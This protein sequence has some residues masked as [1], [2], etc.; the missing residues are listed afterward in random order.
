MARVSTDA[1]NFKHLTLAFI[2]ATVRFQTTRRVGVHDECQQI[3]QHDA[4]GHIAQDYDHLVR[5]DHRRCGR[6]R[7]LSSG[8]QSVAF[9]V[10]AKKV[11]R[12]P[13]EVGIPDAFNTPH[14]PLML[15]IG[16]A[17][18][19]SNTQLRLALL[20]MVAI[21]MTGAVLLRYKGW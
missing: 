9:V 12:Y 14:T 7:V 19:E 4:A 17:D 6:G 10:G 21:C 8:C 20:S 3:S 1:Y 13:L 15:S 18:P 5:S 16:P 11:G 2:R